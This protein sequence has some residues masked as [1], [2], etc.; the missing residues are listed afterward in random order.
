MNC[1]WYPTSQM[2]LKI[3][4][5]SISYAKVLGSIV[6]FNSFYFGLLLTSLYE[7]YKKIIEKLDVHNCCFSKKHG[8]LGLNP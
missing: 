4:T 8:H 2:I 1:I 6:R 7:W 3:L 5:H